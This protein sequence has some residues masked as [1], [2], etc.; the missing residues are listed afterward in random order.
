MRALSLLAAVAAVFCI[1]VAA[2]A[3]TLSGW[4]QLL[5]TVAQQNPSNISALN[6][7]TFDL[8]LS[9]GASDLIVSPSAPFEL[10][11]QGNSYRLRIVNAAALVVDEGG[12]IAKVPMSWKATI[13][14][15]GSFNL[16][17][18][19]IDDCT[20]NLVFRQT[21]GEALN[22]SAMRSSYDVTW[23]FDNPAAIAQSDL[24]GRSLLVR[25]VPADAS[26]VSVTL[27][28]K[29][30]TGSIDVSSPPVP[31]AKCASDVRDKKGNRGVV[32]IRTPGQ[33]VILNYRKE[34]TFKNATHYGV[35]YVT[36]VANTCDL[37]IKCNIKFRLYKYP[38]V[39][40]GI[41][42][43]NGT[44]VAWNEF[45]FSLGSNGSWNQAH[46][47]QTTEK[48]EQYYSWTHPWVPDEAFPSWSEPDFRCSWA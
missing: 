1:G 16:A 44:P 37:P 23:Q 20:F 25:R 33:C 15:P 19:G 48:D 36:G 41:A 46:Y 8:Q 5:D 4:Q 45:D 32:Q 12:L 2:R 39:A 26:P 30:K 47:L 17:I 22:L 31:I 9:A 29:S 34:D 11:G 7:R 28:L 27:R 14:G 40:D 35:N 3:Q 38:S 43:R 21:G 42:R 13:G 6:G 24:N 18:E 10:T